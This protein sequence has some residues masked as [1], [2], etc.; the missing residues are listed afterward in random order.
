MKSMEQIRQDM[1]SLKA[2][3]QQLETQAL[4][5]AMERDAYFKEWG[6]RDE[7]FSDTS[8]QILSLRQLIASCEAV[9]AAT[10]EAQET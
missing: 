8:K 6:K 3:L 9:I 7:A 2:Q 5:L 1:E 10:A 4:N